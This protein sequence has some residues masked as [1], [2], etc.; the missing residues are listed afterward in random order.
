MINFCHKGAIQMAHVTTDMKADIEQRL[1][2]GESLRSIARS[3]GVSYQTLQYHRRNW[4]GEL[5]REARTS[6]EE[7]ASWRGGEYIDRWGYKMVRAPQRDVANPYSP[8]HVLVAEAQIGRQLKKYSE[9]VHHINGDKGDNRPEN[10]LVCT[11]AKHRVLHRQLETIGYELVR[12]GQ[13]EFRDGE[14]RLAE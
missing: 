1:A 4:G 14:Y 13:I 7:H 12:R 11:K 2:N 6:G 10:L 9:V 3:L 8:E 5:L